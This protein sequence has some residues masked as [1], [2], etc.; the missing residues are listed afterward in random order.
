MTMMLLGVLIFAHIAINRV[1]M[2]LV[3]QHKTCNTCWDMILGSKC[4]YTKHNLNFTMNDF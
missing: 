1:N 3:K 4:Q 2:F